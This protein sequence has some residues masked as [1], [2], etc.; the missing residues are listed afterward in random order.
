MGL[1]A[2]LLAALLWAMA[3]GLLAWSLRAIAPAALWQALRDVPASGLLLLLAL[4]GLVLFSLSLRWWLLLRA[5]GHPLPIL[6]L[7]GYRTAAFGLSYFTPGPQFGGEPLQVLLVRRRHG[8]PNET[9]VAAVVVDKSLELLVNLLLLVAGLLFALRQPLLRA[10][11]GDGASRAGFGL[12]ALLALAP[13]VTLAVLALGRRPLAGLAR[14]LPGAGRR[15]PDAMQGLLAAETRTGLLCRN[16]PMALLAALGATLLS[17][18]LLLVEFR[19]MLQVVGLPGDWTTSHPAPDRRAPG[20]S[21]A[22]AGRPGRHGGRP[23]ACAGAA[24]PGA[25]SGPQRGAADSRPRYP[26]RRPGALLGPAPAAPDAV[27][28]GRR[29]ETGAA[30]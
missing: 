3:F 10:L 14:A 30:C 20:L 23:G 4:N 13:L 11:L 28:D 25:G 8:V 1:R 7:V 27:G 29:T 6:P 5:A 9:A 21:A 26:D 17:W 24:G 18:L 2:R 22:P 16:A 15:Y 19:V 12:L